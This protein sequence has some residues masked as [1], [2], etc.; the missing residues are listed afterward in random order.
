MATP[1]S[2]D[3]RNY[4]ASSAVVLVSHS[5]AFHCV[6]LFPRRAF[7][8]LVRPVESEDAALCSVNQAR[9][10]ALTRS[11][12][13]LAS[14]R[15]I[16]DG[17]LNG[18]REAGTWK[19]ERVIVSPQGPMIQV[20]GQTA[21]ILN[22]C[23]NNYLGLSSHPA[24][25]EAGKKAL[26]T[27]G[28][29]LSSVRFICGTQDIHK[30][31]EEKIARFHGR[32][33]TILY[34]SCFDANAGIFEVL[35][36][37]EDAVISDELNHASIID[38]LE[39]HLKNSQNLRQRLIATDGVFSMDGNVAPLNEIC[40]LAD[41]YNA[42]VFIDECHATGFFGK[43]GR[44][45]EEYWGLDGKVDIINS[46]LGKAL[47]GAAGGYTTGPKQLIDLLR[48][49]SRPYLFSNT[50]PPPVVACASKAFDLVMENP[51]L[52]KKVVSNTKRFRSRMT[53]AGFTVAGDPEHAI[54]PVMLGDARLASQFAD[55]M[56]ELGIYVIGF[57]Y[58]V[59]PKGKARIRVQISA[60][61]S[62]QEID[63]AVDAFIK[64]G[65][66]LSVIA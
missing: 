39:S 23:A 37:P 14:T 29:G 59:V 28:A 9:A 57:S 12:S 43:T 45:T 15:T 31:L 54:C 41:K 49:R 32:E 61:H 56:L 21:T 40:A 36:S 58:P 42:L 48:Q 35:L 5:A 17:E 46:T 7:A 65:R 60:S 26:D 52:P 4:S 18:I 13:S 25:I 20:E 50:L 27:H 6:I 22:F 63:R 30:E 24:V 51:D 38:D 62:E 1:L 64:I 47:G 33:D 19:A 53:D 16:L 3:W 55:K 66:E 34:I 2:V 8:D 44:G 10:S 11:S